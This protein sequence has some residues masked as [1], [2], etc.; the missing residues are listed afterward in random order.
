MA[1]AAA[2]SSHNTRKAR[3]GRVEILHR[4]L[5]QIL[6]SDVDPEA[7]LIADG[8]RNGD[9]AGLRH[10]LKS[11]R[12]VHPIAEDVVLLD[13][14]VAKINADAELDPP[15]GWHVAVASRHSA[16]DLDRGVH[17]LDHAGELD[18]H[19]V[20]GGF[21][22]APAVLGD[23]GIDD[24]EAVGAQSRQGAGLIDLHEPAVSHHIGRQNGGELSFDVGL[25]HRHPRVARRLR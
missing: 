15:I 16:L 20:A 24:L 19:A 3:I 9:A 5:A 1:E 17:G 8:Q 22:D 13:D 14:D 4:E 10:R 7:E 23:G 2:A 6:E 21:Y 11:G 25:L 12:H 18:Q